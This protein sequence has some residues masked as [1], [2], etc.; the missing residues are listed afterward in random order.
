MRT[1][2]VIPAHNEEKHIQTVIQET[3]KYCQNI[4][5][6]DDGS[7]DN[8]CNIAKETGVI[9][10]KHLVN[11]GKGAAAK[12][13]CDYAYRKGYKKII[14][15]DA[16][17]QHEAKEIL[18]FLEAIKEKDIVF[19]YRSFNKNMP[20]IFK[21]GNLGINRLN[22]FLFKIDLKDTQSGYRAFNSKAYKQIRWQSP[23]YGMEA[24]MVANVGRKKLNYTQIP[25]KTIYSDNYKGTTIL[26]GLKIGIKMLWWR[27]S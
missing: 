8:T 2:V 3:K 24:E 22:K 18:H 5:V 15:M 10:L 7:S 20:L 17:G 16:D 12:T 21:I 9:T 25:I 11:L 14:L 1:V 13:G 23:D 19:S 6:V 4:I 26:D 27:L